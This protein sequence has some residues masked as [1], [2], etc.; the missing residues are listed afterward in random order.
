VATRIGDLLSCVFMFFQYDPAANQAV[1][2]LQCFFSNSAV[3]H[4]IL[5]ANIIEAFTIVP[6]ALTVLQTHSW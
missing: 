1:Y 2:V 5:L 3:H 4:V 6:Q